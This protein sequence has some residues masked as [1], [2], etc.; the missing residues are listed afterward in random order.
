[1]PNVSLLSSQLTQQAAPLFTQDGQQPVGAA[2]GV[3]P[4]QQG[5]NQQLMDLITMMNL[6]T[7]LQ[8]KGQATQG[9]VGSLLGG[10]GGTPSQGPGPNEVPL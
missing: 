6:L 7:R 8:P 5:D 3:G 1:M 10:K 9:G 2:P 4:T